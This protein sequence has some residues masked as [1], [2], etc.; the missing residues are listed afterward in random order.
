[1]RTSR[2]PVTPFRYDYFDPRDLNAW[3]ETKQVNG[4]FR[5]LGYNGTT[6]YEE[7]AVQGLLA[8]INAAS[9]VNDAA[10]W[11]PRRE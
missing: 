3:L 5:R 1:M 11:Y 6:G 9:R 2:A 7:A 8:G 10:P 4:L